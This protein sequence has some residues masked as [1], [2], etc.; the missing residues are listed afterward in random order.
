MNEP[1]TPTPTAQD[2][3]AID[4]AIEAA[5]QEMDAAQGF[6]R[7]EINWD[8]DENGR[9][10]TS[11]YNEV[12]QVVRYAS[13]ASAKI[14]Q[15]DAQVWVLEKDLRRARWKSRQLLHGVIT[16]L[17]LLLVLARIALQRGLL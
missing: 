10:W 2:L 8:R 3:H 15:L 4:Q 17:A 7:V 16:L 1:T 9:R 11:D 12:A 14:Q 13:Q 6:R 5:H